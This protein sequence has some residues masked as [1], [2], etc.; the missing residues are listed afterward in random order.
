MNFMTQYARS[1]GKLPNRYWYQLNGQAAQQSWMDQRQENLD[2]V[3]ERE[4]D[5]EIIEVRAE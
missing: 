1:C 5:A 4:D 2:A 3:T